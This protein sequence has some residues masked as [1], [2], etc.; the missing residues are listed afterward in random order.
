MRCHARLDRAARLRGTR[1]A[2]SRCVLRALAITSVVLAGCT[3]G[4]G[5]VRWVFTDAGSVDA[6]C[7]PVG[8]DLR[9][10]GPFPDRI[11]C[12]P[13][14]EPWSGLTDDERAA[15]REIGALQAQLCSQERVNVSYMSDDEWRHEMV[16]YPAP[17]QIDV[18]RGSATLMMLPLPR[19][20]FSGCTLADRAA[21]WLARHRALFLVDD[22]V[23]LSLRAAWG[24][25][26]AFD[27]RWR[28][29]DVFF[30]SVDLR[31]S[32][33]RLA[34]SRLGSLVW[35]SRLMPPSAVP[36]VSAQAAI[37]TAFGDAHRSVTPAASAALYVLIGL[38]SSDGHTHLAW[39]ISDGEGASGFVDAIDGSVL[40][41]LATRRCT[42]S[43]QGPNL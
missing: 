40:E 17:G 39:R 7:A 13:P 22:D 6:G 4:E 12:R 1:A 16:G 37:A 41:G 24:D 30:A 21:E 5:T 26:A 38:F 11:P 35:P 19:E 36:A 2:R 33:R 31:W 28:G 25:R 15:E 14:A 9:P 23:E 43:H 29:V 20:A 10:L 34:F 27:E 8:L 18:V 32:E 3:G 42:G